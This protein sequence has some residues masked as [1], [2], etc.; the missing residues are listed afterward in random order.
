MTRAPAQVELAQTLN[1]TFFCIHRPA[2]GD[3]LCLGSVARE[4]SPEGAPAHVALAQVLVA[5]GL[6]DEQLHLSAHAH[7]LRHVR[8]VAPGQLV[9]FGER[10]IYY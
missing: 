6:P 9:P 3:L 2:S 10:R 1:V 8:E 5:G 4:G 7:F